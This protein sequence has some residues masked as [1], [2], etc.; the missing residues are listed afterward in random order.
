MSFIFVIAYY[1]GIFYAIVAGTLTDVLGF[2]IFGQ[3]PD[4]LSFVGYFI[5]FCMSFLNWI[6]GKKSLQESEI[7]RK[8]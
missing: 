1:C 2:F 5:I 4:K 7:A 8:S 3:T 6:H